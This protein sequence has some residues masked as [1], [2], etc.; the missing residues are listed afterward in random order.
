MSAQGGT[1]IVEIQDQGIIWSA[2]IGVAVAASAFL[3]IMAPLGSSLNFTGASPWHSMSASEKSFTLMSAVW[4]ILMQWVSSGIGGYL[5]GRLRTGWIGAHTHEVFFRDTAHGFLSWALATV[6]GAGLLAAS[7]VH[8]AENHG[9]NGSLSEDFAISRLLRT[10]QTNSTITEQDRIDASLALRQ[11]SENEVAPDADKN[12]LQQLVETRTGLSAIDAEK[13]VDD[14]IAQVK[15]T[16]RTAHKTMTVAGLFIFLSMW[17]G[18]FIASAAG[19]LGGRHRD[20]HYAT[21]N[22]A[23]D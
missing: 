5:T 17:I 1:G 4:L 18:A 23:A 19:A 14:T 15:E 22:L 8:M 3:I 11:I 2:I 6:L 20:L 16:F 10:D 9:V 21:G 7:A 12:Y 13:R